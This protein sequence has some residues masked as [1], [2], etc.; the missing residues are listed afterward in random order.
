MEEVCIGCYGK[1]QWMLNVFRIRWVRGRVDF[2]LP[3]MTRMQSHTE[4]HTH[5]HALT[6]TYTNQKH[7]R[8]RGG[9]RDGKRAKI[10]QQRTA[11]SLLDSSCTD[12]LPSGATH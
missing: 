7:K 10:V 9:E 8:V 1:S 11:L 2:P 4:A 3:W 12:P 6:H 5:T